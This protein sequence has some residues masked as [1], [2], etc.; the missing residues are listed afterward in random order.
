MCVSR[1]NLPW[2]EDSDGAIRARNALRA[3]RF[4]K[5]RSLPDWWL[6]GPRRGVWFSVCMSIQQADELFAEARSFEAEADRQ[7]TVVRAMTEA[8][9]SLWMGPREER[10]WDLRLKAQRLKRAARAVAVL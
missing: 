10:V 2:S 1:L 6:R 3:G 8:Q 5:L 7:Q 4:G 9:E